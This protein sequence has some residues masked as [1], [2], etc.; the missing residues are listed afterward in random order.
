MSSP[1]PACVPPCSCQPSNSPAS[2]TGAPGCRA[3]LLKRF[4]QPAI[5]PDDAYAH[6]GSILTNLTRLKE[7]RCV[8]LQPG[9]GLLSALQVLS[10]L[11]GC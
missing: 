6:V 8:L 4:M 7:A 11:A 5:P 3:I 2:H 10:A 9:R 1:V